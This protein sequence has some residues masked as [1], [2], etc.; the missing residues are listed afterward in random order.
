MKKCFIVGG[1]RFWTI[2]MVGKPRHGATPIA[3]PHLKPKALWFIESTALNAHALKNTPKSPTQPHRAVD[4]CY[5][6]LKADTHCFDWKSGFAPSQTTCLA[7]SMIQVFFLNASKCVRGESVWKYRI[8][9]HRLQHSTKFR[10]KGKGNLGEKEEESRI[11]NLCSERLKSLR[12]AELKH[13]TVSNSMHLRNNPLLHSYLNSSVHFAQFSVDPDN[14]PNMTRVW[15]N[16]SLRYVA[17]RQRQFRRM[18]F[19]L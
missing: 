9:R 2:W 6:N 7:Q 13:L 17:E 3:Q 16:S 1:L 14:I 15:I 11:G 18:V 4:I 5:F 8:L 12:L 10:R 19:F